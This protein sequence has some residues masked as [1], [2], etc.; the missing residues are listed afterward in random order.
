MPTPAIMSSFCYYHSGNDTNASGVD[1]SVCIG[2]VGVVCFLIG[3]FLVICCSTF[4]AFQSR[5]QVYRMLSTESDDEETTLWEKK[6]RR[7][8]DTDF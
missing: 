5:R 2:M 3:L 4:K 7:D 8:S 1:M 6:P